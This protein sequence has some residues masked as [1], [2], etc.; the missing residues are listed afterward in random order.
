MDSY[1]FCD[2]KAFLVQTS[3]NILQRKQVLWITSLG[4]NEY[5]GHLLAIRVVRGP[6]VKIIIIIKEKEVGCLS[7]LVSPSTYQMYSLPGSYFHVKTYFLTDC[8]TRVPI[9]YNRE[10]GHNVMPYFRLTY[11]L[12]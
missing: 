8:G 11:F 4:I 9:T 6:A 1:S 3:P 5:Y 10:L 12:F 7:H 2:L